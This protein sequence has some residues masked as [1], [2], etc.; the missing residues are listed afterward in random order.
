MNGNIASSNSALGNNSLIWDLSEEIH[1]R[2]LADEQ[3]V[4]EALIQA[5]NMPSS[6]VA[7]AQAFASHLIRSIRLRLS[8]ATGLHALLSYYDLSSQE[9]IV[10]MCL[11]EALLRIPDDATVDALIADKLASGQWQEHLGK[12]ESLFVNAST[13]ALLLTGRLLKPKE[14]NNQASETFLTGL[15]SRMEEPVLR[16]AIRHAMRVIAEQY[17]MGSTIN[18]ALSR[19]CQQENRA[20]RYSF[21]MLGETALIERDA[22]RYLHA[23]RDAIESIGKS[24]N[25][26]LPLMQ[27]PG[28]SIKLSALFPRYEFS[29]QKHALAVLTQRLLVLATDARQ[30]GISLT[31]DAEETEQL[32]LSLRIFAKVFTDPALSGW[33]G[34][35]LAVQ[36]Y[37][38]RA[39]PVLEFINKLAVRESK[40]I[41]VRLVKG[42]YWDTEIKHAQQQGLKEYPVFTR[43]N[44]TDVSYLA[45]ANYLLCHSGN[46][47]PQFATHN[48]YTVAAILQLG[49]GYDY[50][51]QR[52]HGMGEELYAELFESL[53]VGVSCRVYAPVGAHKDLLPYLVRRLLENGANTSFVNQLAHPEQPIEELVTDP[54]EKAKTSCEPL[55]HVNIPLPAELFGDDR[56]NSKGVN[57]NDEREVNLLLRQLGAH[58][59]V[60]FHS[61]PVIAGKQI[62]GAKHPVMD[63]ANQTVL[64]GYSEVFAGEQ[65]CELKR[66]VEIAHNS[67]PEWRDTAVG[68]RV[69]ILQRA[70]DLL[71]QHQAELLSLCV[72]EAG[73]TL[74][75]SQA[76]I[77][78]AIDFLRYYCHV[79]LTLFAEP[80]VLPGFTG[81]SNELYL[82]GRGV[83]VC[84]SPW[85]FPLAIFCG[86]IA[87]ALVTGNS[88]LAKPA[89]ATC[90][91][92]ARVTE[93]LYKAGVPDT[94]L[95]FLPCRAGQFS[96]VILTDER[97]AGVA[98]T[99]SMQAAQ[100]INRVLAN[101]NGSI[102]VLI[103]E[104]GGQNALLADS[105]A[106]PEQ[107]VLD[108]LQSAFN[109]AGQRCSALRVLYVQDE[110]APRVIELIKGAMGQLE[111]GS[112]CELQTDVGPVISAEAKEKL[113]LHIA[114]WRERGALLYQCELPITCQ[115]GHF[116]APA[117][118]EIDSIAQLPEECFGP[119][120]HV[121]RYD[122]TQMEQVLNEINATNYGL[123]FGLH[124]RLEQR[125]E[126]VCERIEAGNLY[127]NR[128]TVGAVVGV[129]PFG[130]RG[131]SGTG[132]KAGGPH[133]LQRFV[134]EQTVTV[135]T[136]A[137]G[138]N[139]LLL[140]QLK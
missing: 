63:P 89:S 80:C 113:G 111:I 59:D 129:Q 22:L 107:L 32:V 112:P 21:D 23:Y 94:V 125:V 70:A 126:A 6:Q 16:A 110:I 98:F 65:A 127:I 131:L 118:I 28:I 102:A 87:A 29:Q 8:K 10:L 84:I 136:A 88:V 130:G 34:L 54:I 93:L 64:V 30:A 48:A 85:N 12:S 19:S 53:A 11:A 33:E 44:N 132:P 50:E 49:K 120:L 122:S 26:E 79:A 92:A 115:S 15:A 9:G 24:S 96:E 36:A 68:S 67:W 116:V 105:S 57:F 100:E 52:L 31:V 71:E 103:A 14:L 119:V 13:W 25:P 72:R 108:V 137:A 77:R 45:C 133:Y 140:G 5:V 123:T 35:G 86:Q 41:P 47:Y 91:V 139:A 95:Q 83:F 74:R 138:G 56:I 40:K 78:E 18:A 38:K 75:D 37:Q 128:D 20:N 2:Y 27:R 43:K 62:S 3:V 121:I 7:D 109:S 117:L 4:V 124:S 135:N 134:T 60:S 69:D 17:V 104:T 106:L 73:K 82:K 114:S 42:A 81:E 55:R 51:F 46:L 61:M 101:R 99:G 90:L 39:M 58:C 66:A 76:E 1:E 97:I